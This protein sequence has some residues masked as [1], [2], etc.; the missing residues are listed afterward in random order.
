MARISI[1]FY[2]DTLKVV[3]SKKGVLLE[4]LSYLNWNKNELKINEKKGKIN[5]KQKNLEKFLQKVFLPL[6]ADFE[7]NELIISGPIN[8][9]KETKKTIKNFFEG[10][11]LKSLH[12]LP[13]IFLLAIGAR[14]DLND[15]YGNIILDINF[16]QTEAAIIANHKIINFE[17]LNFGENLLNSEIIIFF[18]EKLQIIINQSELARVKFHL[19]SLTSNK[20]EIGL[21][22]N[23]KDLVTE[24]E[25]Q[26]L[27]TDLEVKKLFT[28]LFT[29]YR[30]MIIHML[31][32]SPGYIRTGIAK[33]GLLITGNLAK[34]NGVADYFAN[35]FEFPAQAL[36]LTIDD[37]LQETFKIVLE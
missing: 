11:N 20:Q 26:V 25:K 28:S 7:K 4:N 36:D 18:K 24:K 16:E 3:H 30:S 27:V 15:D 12:F 14:L 5:N 37:L 23:G 33:N 32:K 10:F 29:N 19:A 31:E 2:N 9:A 35:F 1:V 21:V 13:T 22:F 8:V 34:I 6:K 17:V